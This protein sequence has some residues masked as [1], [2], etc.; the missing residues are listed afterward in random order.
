VSLGLYAVVY[1][2]IHMYVDYESF[3]EKCTWTTTA[4]W[5]Q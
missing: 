4:T 5:P 2:L 1:D 3:V